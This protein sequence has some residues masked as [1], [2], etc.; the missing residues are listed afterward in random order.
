MLDLLHIIL[1]RIR[2][3]RPH[4]ANLAV[5]DLHIFELESESNTTGA[6]LGCV[7]MEFFERFVSSVWGLRPGAVALAGDRFGLSTDE[8]HIHKTNSTGKSRRKPFFQF[9]LFFGALAFVERWWHSKNRVVDSVPA[10]AYALAPK[11]EGTRADAVST[12]DHTIQH[13]TIRDIIYLKQTRQLVGINDKGTLLF[14]PWLAAFKALYS[15][16]KT[17]TTRQSS[18]AVA[19][20][21]THSI[22][23]PH[24]YSPSSTAA[25]SDSE[26]ENPDNNDRLGRQTRLR[27]VRLVTGGEIMT[28]ATGVTRVLVSAAQVERCHNLDASDLMNV[29]GEANAIGW[30]GMDP[31][32]ILDLVASQITFEHRVCMSFS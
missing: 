14:W 32:F 6:P 4:A 31:W 26:A 24:M 29:S 20:H 17:T 11:S 10:V 21:A 22:R 7:P 16:S 3:N 13:C 15:A 2:R 5:A 12:I 8:E 19:F 18:Q 30:G 1:S 9:A 25:W 27:A 23:C 28:K